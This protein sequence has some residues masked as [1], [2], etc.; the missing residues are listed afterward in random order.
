MSSYQKLL[1][2]LSL[3]KVLLKKGA[4]PDY[5]TL[6]ELMIWG[7]VNGSL[8]TKRLLNMS[9]FCAGFTLSCLRKPAEL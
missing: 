2:V 4:A 3:K 5:T 1:L 6:R 7:A 8:K 9:T